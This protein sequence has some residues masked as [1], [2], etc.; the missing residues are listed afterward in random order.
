[1]LHPFHPL[2]RLVFRFRHRPMIF[3]FWCLAPIGKLTCPL[4]ASVGF[5][6]PDCSFTLFFFSDLTILFQ[7]TPP[8]LQLR[9]P[10]SS[11]TRG[12]RDPA[13]LPSD[14]FPPLG[15]CVV[16][17]LSFSDLLTFFSF[18]PRSL[19]SCSAILDVIQAPLPVL[20]PSL[21]L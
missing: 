6:L 2:L 5:P 7:P 1:L 21:R 3:V 13:A 19:V 4:N 8:F 10:P 15:L 17:V 9:P 16:C 14:N 11:F 12:S 18:S 20:C